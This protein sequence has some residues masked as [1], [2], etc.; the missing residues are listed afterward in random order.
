MRHSNQ[1]MWGT[2]IYFAVNAQYSLGGYA[3]KN[4]DGS[5]SIFYVRV[6]VGDDITL[7]KNGSYKIPPEKPAASGRFAVERF[8]SIKGNTNGSDIY[9]VYENSRAYPDYLIT[10]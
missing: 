4:N 10:F 3:Y 1:G 9:I 2:G 5:K 6:A 8:D 7:P